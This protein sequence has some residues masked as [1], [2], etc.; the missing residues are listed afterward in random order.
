MSHFAFSMQIT[1]RDLDLWTA[2]AMRNLTRTVKPETCTCTLN[3]TL[4]QP[5]LALK[6]YSQ[7]IEWADKENL[8]QPFPERMRT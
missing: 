6:I 2:L 1:C 7:P 8:V 5:N 4:C 3:N